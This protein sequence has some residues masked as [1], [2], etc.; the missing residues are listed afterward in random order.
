MDKPCEDKPLAPTSASFDASRRA[1]QP[2]PT[3]LGALT[4]R[5]AMSDGVFAQTAHASHSDRLAPSRA[6][7]GPEPI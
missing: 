7:P 5:L 4:H 3:S 1:T 6:P 2:T